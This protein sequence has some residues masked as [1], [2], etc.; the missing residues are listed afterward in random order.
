MESIQKVGIVV[1]AVL[2]CAVEVDATLDKVWVIFGLVDDDRADAETENHED[3][4]GKYWGVNRVLVK[5]VRMF[6]KILV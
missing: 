2:C 6:K 5:K 3:D 4:K 1:E